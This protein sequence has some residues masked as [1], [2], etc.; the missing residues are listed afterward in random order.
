MGKFKS[1]LANFV[2]YYKWHMLIALFFVVVL[3]VLIFQMCTQDKYDVKVM[4]AGPAIVSDTSN[5]E[6]QNVLSARG[7]DYDKNGKVSALLYDLVIMS[8]DELYAAYDKGYQPTVLNNG[9]INENRKT[10][11]FHALADEFFLMLLSPECY[12]ILY[13]NDRLVPLDTMGIALDGTPLYDARYDDCGLYLH[14][15]DFAKFYTAFSVLPEDTIGC[16]KKVAKTEK[17]NST[18]EISQKNHI[19][20]FKEMA[21]FKLPPDYVPPQPTAYADSLWT[22]ELPCRKEDSNV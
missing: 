3:S 20:F 7:N 12:E 19:N 14:D 22:N 11:S 17:K 13:T 15:L 8:E 4:Y 5:A 9:I 16:V 2:Y 21:E 1:K 18:A 6:I 10:F